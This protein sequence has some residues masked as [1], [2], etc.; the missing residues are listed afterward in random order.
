MS[1]TVQSF[2]IILIGDG[3]SGKTTF[4]MR[5]LTGEYEK[6][7][8]PTVGVE[9]HPLVFYT[10]KGKIVFNVWDTAGQEKY[11][12]LRKAYYTDAD[13]A[14]VFFDTTSAT[15]KKTVGS[16]ESEVPAGIPR[17]TCGTKVENAPPG[18][19]SR[20]CCVSARSS[21][22]FSKPFLKIARKLLDDAEL[23]FV[24]GPAVTPPE[25]TFVPVVAP[26]VATGC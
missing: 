23:K 19:S 10:T 13:A 2:K 3:G 26:P 6:K 4:L 17:V 15:S 1:T 14:L 25:L 11:C 24:E 20:N 9:V 18:F 12:G 16:W 8:N 7:Y 5:H 22:N 21:I